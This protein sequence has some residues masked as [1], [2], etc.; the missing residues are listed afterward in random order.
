MLNSYCFLSSIIKEYSES[1]LKKCNFDINV[2]SPIASN[3]LR[4]ILNKK[5]KNEIGHIGFIYAKKN[6][7]IKID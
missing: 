2:T 7:D 6:K 3:V 5:T 1:K 4:K